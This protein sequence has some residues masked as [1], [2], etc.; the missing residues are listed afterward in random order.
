MAQEATVAFPSERWLTVRATH[1]RSSV[2]LKAITELQHPGEASCTG[3]QAREAVVWC[4]G[5]GGSA[6]ERRW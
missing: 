2:A 3:S 6:R 1:G 4:G 5:S